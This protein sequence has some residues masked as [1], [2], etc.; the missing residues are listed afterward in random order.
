[1]EQTKRSRAAELELGRFRD[2]IES[3]PS[4]SQ[5]QH[6]VLEEALDLCASRQIESLTRS[7]CPIVDGCTT[8]LADVLNEVAEIRNE[9]AEKIFP[10]L[11][12]YESDVSDSADQCHAVRD[13]AAFLPVLLDLSRFLARTSSVFRNLLFQI[14]GFHGLESKDL[15][16]ASDRNLFRAWFG[17]GELLTILLQTDKIIECRP[18]IRND[19]N[20]Y[21]RAI[22]TAQHNPA[23]FGVTFDEIRPLISTIATID[24]QVMA[25][26]G[27]RN[28]YEQSYGELDEDKKFAARMRVAIIEIYN[29][30][31][32]AA[33]SDMPDKYRL[34]VIVSLFV[35]HQLHFALNDNKLGRIIWKS[36]K[37]IMAFHMI[38]DILWIPCEFLMR[39]VPAIVNAVDMKSVQL[40]KHVRETLMAE[41]SD[42]ML[43]EATSYVP[44]A[45][46]WQTKMRAE[47]R[48]QEP[49]DAAASL[50]V[51]ELILKGA[52]I[53][54]VM[55]SL[56]RIVLNSYTGPIRMSK[57]KAYK[58]F[59]IIENIKAISHTFAESRRML[60][61]CCQMA[62][63]QW[64]CHS[65]A[66]IDRVRLSARESG[67]IHRAA[68]FQIAIQCL[69][70]TESRCRLCV[71]GVALEIAQYKDSM[72]KVDSAQL[73]ALISRLDTFCKI[74][75]I[76]ERVAN[77]SFLLFHRDLIGIY[78]DTVLDRTPTRQSIM[79]FAMAVS[80]CIRY[81]K[82][83]QSDIQLEH[84]RREM[85]E[86]IKKGFLYPLCAAIENDLRILSH[87]HLVIDERDKPT[88][89]QLEFYKEILTDPEVRLHGEVLNISEFVSCYLQKTFYDL[90]AVTLHDRHAYSRMATLAE[91]RYGLSLIDGM[92]P[93]CSIGQSLDVVKVMR[94]LGEF[95]S[96]FNYCLNQQLF[97]EKMSPNRTL[98]VLTAEHMA[99]SMRTQGLG[100]LNTSV[101]IT[102]QLLRSKFGI[103]N[104]FLR[105]EHIHAQLQK[106]IRYFHENLQPLKKL[107]PPK[108]AEQFN[109]AFSQLSTQLG[110]ISYM[111]RFRMLITQMGNALGFV[112]SMSSGAAAVASQMKAYDTIEDDITCSDM[113]DDSPLNTAKKLLQE[114]REQANKNRDFT[115]M[116][117]EVF[118]SAFLDDSKFSHLLD[119]YVAVPALMV[120]YVEHMLI[121]R[122]RLKKRAQLHKEITFTDDGFIMGLAYILTVL[123][124]WPQFTSLNWFRSITKKCAADHEAL[125]EEMKTSKDSRGVHLKATRLQ[126]YE[127]EFKLLSFTFQSARVYFSVDDHDD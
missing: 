110:E 119:F 102:Y 89:E 78:W 44:A 80:D 65:L 111:D 115:K 43:E 108:R 4:T 45:E 57:T 39:E 85:F 12:L 55:C 27:L 20:S 16:E 122:D 101:N 24:C 37:K 15:P 11:L 91:Q 77:C 66:L 9:A 13:M 84:F 6:R 40:V 117:V 81:V 121:C 34:M 83:S 100:V 19:W 82:K 86:L 17:L 33:D 87:Q 98:R 96:N 126:A 92:L 42:A 90:T 38:G 79:Y 75:S 25:G 29:Q 35:F 1:M 3:L 109:S 59:N 63:L 104:Q 103:F 54:D 26:N 41:Q 70:G 50:A 28:C 120:N 74:D 68:A 36:H 93:N 64:R 30:W 99:D 67:D 123:N 73:D 105:D 124:L 53:A 31:E 46:D 10:P 113:E 8:I 97:I 76:I 61:E 52:R 127:R 72:R 107:F 60:L 88:E 21:S 95:V 47:V 106:D 23:Q 112:R 118:R 125:T 56:L 116:L 58:M 14:R 2:L 22:G 71:C 49:R 69:L 32:K 18:A 48:R 5:E 7:G 114:L 51:V 94:S 62:C